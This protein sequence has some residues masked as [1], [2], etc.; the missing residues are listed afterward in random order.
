MQQTRRRR[1]DDDEPR[2][3]A[4]P[5]LVFPPQ[6]PCRRLHAAVSPTGEDSLNGQISFERIPPNIFSLSLSLSLLS[7]LHMQLLIGTFLLRNHDT[8]RRL[9]LAGWGNATV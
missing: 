6:S 3:N 1:R 5:L 2:K 9:L 4:F 7:L 8:R